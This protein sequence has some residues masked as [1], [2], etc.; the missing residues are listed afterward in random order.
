VVDFEDSK[1][2]VRVSVGEG[3]E[4]CSEKDV[5]GHSV[6][7]GVGERV[8]GVTAASDEEGAEGDGE[9]LMEFGG[10]AMDFGEVFT[11]EDGDGYGVVKHERLCIVELVSGAAQGYAE[12]GSRW[13]GV[14]HEERRFA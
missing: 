6:C 8:F 1:L 14:L 4:A 13:A 12:S 11:A 3:V 9:G 5:L 7:D 10:G 2:W